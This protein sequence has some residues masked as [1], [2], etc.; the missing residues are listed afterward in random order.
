[1]VANVR[2][3]S[4]RKTFHGNPLL[5]LS[6][7]NDTLYN[8]HWKKQNTKVYNC[9]FYLWLRLFDHISGIHLVLIWLFKRNNVEQSLAAL[10]MITI[11]A[12]C[13]GIFSSSM[14]AMTSSAHFSAVIVHCRVGYLLKMTA[15]N[16]CRFRIIRSLTGGPECGHRQNVHFWKGDISLI[17]DQIN[18]KI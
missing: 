15:H 5:V 11:C 4:F 10:T 9:T 2:I 14:R 16:G 18:R 17:A 3:P 1:M 8:H 6:V 7:L 12:C 13:D